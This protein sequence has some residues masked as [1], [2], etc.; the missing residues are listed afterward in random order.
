MTKPGILLRGVILGALG[1][2]FFD[3]ERGRRR[4]ALA[5]D[6][7]R[8]QSRRLKHGLDQAVRDL[9]HRLQGYVAEGQA[10][11][12][13]ETVPDDVLIER[14][15]SRL[16]RHVSHPRAIDVDVSD[17]Q[18]MLSGAIPSA[19][20]LPL[21][22]AVAGVRGVRGVSNRLDAVDDIAAV[23]Q[24]RGP[25]RH[26][27]RG[28]NAAT[29]DWNP[30]TR[31]LVGGAGGALLANC[32]LRRGVRPKLKGAVGFGMLLRAATN[33]GASDLFGL[34][35]RGGAGPQRS[36]PIEAPLEKV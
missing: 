32:L 14:V 26:G 27:G 12:R 21:V 22:R 9:E 23:D 28:Q 16:G 20:V 35:G 3:P 15:R 2:Y 33:R 4:R 7:A 5:A 8:R 13:S 11:V 19:E 30:A 29:G 17:G 18:V 10:L 36:L 24:L 31:L 25:G 34:A 6:Q 1:A